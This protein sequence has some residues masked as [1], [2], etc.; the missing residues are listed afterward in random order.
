LELSR[1]IAL[2]YTY[3]SK[4]PQENKIGIV[5][6]QKKNY[7]LTNKITKLYGNVGFQLE[8]LKQHYFLLKPCLTIKF[9]IRS[10]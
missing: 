6:K 2:K 5:E 8:A 3:A 7:Q 4:F 1:I 9:Q 10:A